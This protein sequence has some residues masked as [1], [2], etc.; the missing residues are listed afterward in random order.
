LIVVSPMY[1]VFTLAT[2]AK[3]EYMHSAVQP[4]DLI[5]LA[6]FMPLFRSFFGTGVLVTGIVGLGIWIGA[7]VAARRITPCQVPVTRR[8]FINFLAIVILLGLPAMFALAPSRPW[9]STLMLRLGGPD[10]EHRE[11]ARRNGLLLSFMS[12]IPTTFVSAPPN[13]S[14][15]TVIATLGK[16]QRIGMTPAGDARKNGVNLIIYLVESLMDPDDLGFRYTAD[17]IPNLRALRKAHVSGY[18]IVPER[19]GGSANTEFEAL[20]GMT[21]SFLPEGSVPYRQY[22]RHR[23]LSLPCALNRLGYTT[24]AIQADPKYYYDRERVYNLL[25]FERTMWLRDAQGITRAP[26]GPWPSDQAVVDAVVQASRGLHPFFV[27]AFPSSTHA[28]YNFG[29]YR[30]SDLDVVNPPPGDTLGEVKEYVNAVRDADRAIGALIEHF[31]HQPDSTIIAVF[32]DHVPPLSSRALQ[33][34]FEIMTGLSRTEQLRR[35]HRV[36]LLIWANFDLPREQAELSINGLPSFLL[37]K[38]RIP[39][40]GFLAV[41]DAVRREVPTLASYVRGADGRL[42]DQDSLPPEH[43]AVVD[44]YR[45]LQYDLLLGKQYALRDGVQK[46][47]LVPEPRP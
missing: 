46:W 23:V 39:A 33:R 7:L 22:L 32:G 20:T 10:S 45:L 4:L 1:M 35:L 36:P 14:P 18:A 21:R 15:A 38:M 37:D 47:C 43:R 24:I 27:F 5:R 3:I 8:V 6:E 19:F 12:E 13:Y 42:W 28:P 30:H 34:F 44:D 29:T 40:P 16:Y 41:T 31:R 26:R 9:V 17:P 25:G 2:L 11:K